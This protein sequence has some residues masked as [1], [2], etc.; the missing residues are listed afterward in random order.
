MFTVRE[1][2]ENYQTK[3]EVNEG[4]RQHHDGVG[5]GGE[6]R[7]SLLYALLQDETMGVAV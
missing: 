4:W 6:G 1:G 3:H 5:G 7:T 2:P